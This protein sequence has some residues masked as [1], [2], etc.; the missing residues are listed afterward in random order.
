MKKISVREELLEGVVSFRHGDGWLQP[1][2]LREEDIP[3]HHERLVD[4]AMTTSGCRL[5]FTTNAKSVTLT[6]EPEGSDRLFDLTT[7]DTLVATATLPA[8]GTQVRFGDLPHGCNVMEIW[9]PI[10]QP[11]RL[12]SLFMDDGTEL[13]P[14][15][16]SRPRWITYG[17]SIT[18]CHAAH[19]PSRTWPAVAARSRGLNLTSLGYGGNCQMDPLVAMMIRDLPADLISLKVG[20]NLWRDSASQRTFRPLLIGMVRLIRE[21]HPS[22]PIAVVSPILSPP[23]EETP[24]LTGMTLRMMREELEVAVEQLRSCGDRNVRYFNGLELLGEDLVADCLPD[25]LHPN[26]DGYER[27]GHRFA[28]RVVDQ[29]LGDIQP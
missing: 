27:I 20:V 11:T 17:S 22:I 24:G 14:S 2:R 13:L 25:L 28:E 10:A 7:H 19:S 18:H 6:A 3:L 15:P 12:R 26:G 9:L 5:R 8:G 16:D 4:Q 21:K 23:R 1:L 29:M